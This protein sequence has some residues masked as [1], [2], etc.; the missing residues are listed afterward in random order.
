M[1][2]TLLKQIG[3]HI[4]RMPNAVKY[5]GK[6]WLSCIIFSPLLF[7]QISVYYRLMEHGYI[8]VAELAAVTG[9]LILCNFLLSLPAFFLILLFIFRINN[10]QG[11]ALNRK[12]ILAVIIL[13]LVL[14]TFRL[15]FADETLYKII[16]TEFSWALLAAY[17]VM[18]LTSIFIYPLNRD[19]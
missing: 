12:M 9:F 1:A 7:I 19:I 17:C 15:V 14:L 18:T 11:S 13:P 5:L 10:V 8:N 6:V 16:H 2:G 3:Y 4:M